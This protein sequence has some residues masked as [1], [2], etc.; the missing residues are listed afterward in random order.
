[1]KARTFLIA[2]VACSVFPAGAQSATLTHKIDPNWTVVTRD[3][4]VD[5]AAQQWQYLDFAPRDA[6]FGTLQSFTAF[7]DSSRNTSDLPPVNGMLE[8]RG[9]ASNKVSAHTELVHTQDVPK[10]ISEPA[11]ELLMLVALAVLAI[12]VRRKMPE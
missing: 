4:N 1:M 7:V 9:V 5:V 2:L 11:S 8:S 6:A 10:R 3:D 12:M